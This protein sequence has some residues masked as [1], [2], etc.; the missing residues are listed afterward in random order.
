MNYTFERLILTY[1]IIIVALPQLIAVVNCYLSNDITT[2]S[3]QQTMVRSHHQTNRLRRELRSSSSL[4][5]SL[6]S[7][8]PEDD[9]DSIM[10]NLRQT[11][12]SKK[13]RSIDIPIG[14]YAADL[15]AKNHNNAKVR[16]HFY[17]FG[18]WPEGFNTQHGWGNDLILSTDG[19]QEAPY[20]R[21]K[22]NSV[23]HN[24]SSKRDRSKPKSDKLNNDLS[25][26]DAGRH[27]FG[28]LI[29]SIKS[30]FPISKKKVARR[31]KYAQLQKKKRYK[32]NFY[33]TNEI[34]FGMGGLTKDKIN[35]AVRLFGQATVGEQNK[36]E[37]LYHTNH[38]YDNL[39][40]KKN[41]IKNSLEPWILAIGDAT[42]GHKTKQKV[43]HQA[44]EVQ[45]NAIPYLRQKFKRHHAKKNSIYGR[46]KHK[47]KNNFYQ[48]N[49]VLFG[50][51]GINKIKINEIV[52]QFGQATLG[53]KN[54][55]EI[56]YHTDQIHADLDE[57][58]N[59]IK[60]NLEPWILAIGDATIGHEN[61][62][63]VRHQA[64]KI[65]QNAIPY[66]KQNLNRLNPKKNGSFRRDK[67]KYQNNFYK[68]NEILFGPGGITKVKIDKIVKQF[69]Q[70]TIGE[71]N[72]DEFLHHTNE[73]F[74]DWDRRKNKIKNVV[75]P[76]ILAIGDAT[77]GSN[78]KHYLKQKVHET[79]P[80]HIPIL[81]RN[82][83]KSHRTGPIGSR[84][85]GDPTIGSNKKHYLK[86]KAHETKRN[87]IPILKRRL[88]KSRGTGSRS[89]QSPT[90]I[91]E[92]LIDLK[93]HPPTQAPKKNR[94]GLIGQL[95]ITA[96][97]FSNHVS[98]TK[99]R[100]VQ[101][102]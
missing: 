35:N 100:P 49:E 73:I 63:R 24:L 4:G 83:N 17:Q 51:G 55:D 42:I 82:L 68:T 28:N 85:I 15:G 99:I 45:K 40:E 7:F 75:D 21:N 38:V 23:S 53:E 41:R 102:I 67:R 86:L 58:K 62:H 54:K 98:N 77:I 34:L 47:Y 18:G 80:N 78:K 26:F 89:H 87:H 101:Y 92:R 31:K 57:K 50:P 37:I 72:K 29:N 16:K 11:K 61:K 59:R 81:K 52:K 5:T 10:N 14:R 66:L 36:D 94:I 64:H 8:F 27:D 25:Q 84:L 1:T 43:R 19:Y 9:G 3:H 6:P 74:S 96:E 76:L 44:Y 79:K 46:D 69:G 70:A 32:D 93:N 22:V 48:T 2:I 88:N 91:M 60:N 13:S 30:I 95:I 39:N 20:T 90:Q 12:V 97:E 65:Q 33:K 71:E 56:L